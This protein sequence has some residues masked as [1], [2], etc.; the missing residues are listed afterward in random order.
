MLFHAKAYH[1]GSVRPHKF[2]VQN[3]SVYNIQLCNWLETHLYYNCCHYRGWLSSAEIKKSAQYK[4]VKGLATNR[5]STSIDLMQIW[6]LLI[7][8]NRISSTKEMNPIMRKSMSKLVILPSSE[9]LAK[10]TQNGTHV[11][12]SKI[13]DKRMAVSQASNICLQFMLISSCHICRR[14]MPNWYKVNFIN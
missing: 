5:H 4:C 13:R 14:W 8:I 6:W 9:Q 12:N 2:H 10:H 7:S 11:T 1:T 3:N